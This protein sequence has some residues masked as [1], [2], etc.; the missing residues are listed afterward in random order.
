MSEGVRAANSRAKAN[1]IIA[2]AK[3]ARFFG[4]RISSSDC[5]RPLDFPAAAFLPPA[6]LDS[7]W[8]EASFD[9]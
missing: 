6:E 3:A 7:D 8:F 1:T 4:I 2:S 9:C 5:R